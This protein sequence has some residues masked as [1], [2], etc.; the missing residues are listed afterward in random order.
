ML[1][2]SFVPIKFQIGTTTLIY[3]GKGQDSDIMNWRP[4]TIFSVLRHVI[5][6]S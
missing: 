4:I 3:K 5:E 2:E 6:H 1:R